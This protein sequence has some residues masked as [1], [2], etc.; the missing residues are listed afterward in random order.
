VGGSV[1]ARKDAEGAKGMAPK[2]RAEQSMKCG[3]HTVKACRIHTN[4]V[5]DLV[6]QEGSENQQFEARKKRKRKK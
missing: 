2:G 5:M 6:G 1:Q 3:M 4:I